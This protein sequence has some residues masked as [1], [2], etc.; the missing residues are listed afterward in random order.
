MGEWMRRA[1]LIQCQST[2]AEA[3]KREGELLQPP[4]SAGAE[5]EAE[6]DYRRNPERY[7]LP[8]FAI[9]TTDGLVEFQ[10]AVPKGK[11]DAFAILELFVKHHGLQEAAAGN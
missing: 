5:A 8:R 6:P 11:Y 7:E 1:A 10:L 3:G 9:P 4:G 2:S